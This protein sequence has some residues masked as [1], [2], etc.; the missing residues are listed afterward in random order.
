MFAD[1]GADQTQGTPSRS[2]ASRRARG[3]V[4]WI[5]PRSDNWPRSRTSSPEYRRRIA[6][7][8]A[9]RDNA[10]YKRAVPRAVTI[11]RRFC[12]MPL[13]QSGPPPNPSAPLGRESST[14][15]SRGEVAVRA[16]SDA[17]VGA[18]RRLAG[19]RTAD[20]RFL[21]RRHLRGMVSPKGLRAPLVGQ[22][23]R[24]QLNEPRASRLAQI[25][26]P[27]ARAIISATRTYPIGCQGSEE[28]APHGGARYSEVVM[29]RSLVR[30]Y[31]SAVSRPC[32][33]LHSYSR[34]L[35]CLRRGRSRS[36]QRAGSNRAGHSAGAPGVGRSDQAVGTRSQLPARC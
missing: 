5:R 14:G 15:R 13:Q 11:E 23:S 24:L 1:A 9:T 10:G 18:W 27:P 35:S 17:A 25:P 22:F 19:R 3:P 36:D 12:T 6:R 34:Q 26:D 4:V 31:P 16:G 29:T 32:W 33:W 2:H 28:F 8:S 7:R 21:T 30:A 20:A